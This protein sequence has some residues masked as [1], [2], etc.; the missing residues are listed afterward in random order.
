MTGFHTVHSQ[1]DLFHFDK[2]Q[3]KFRALTAHIYPG[4]W[5]GGGGVVDRVTICILVQSSSAAKLETSEQLSVI[6]RESR[7]L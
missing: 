2:I 6:C 4:A 7:V 5:V 3:M 1:Q